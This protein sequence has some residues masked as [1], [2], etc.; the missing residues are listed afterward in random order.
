MFFHKQNKKPKIIFI[1]H[2]SA[3]GGAPIL[4]LNLL[5]WIKEN[6]DLEFDI[7]IRKKGVLVDEFK[8]LGKTIFFPKKIN[9]IKRL[10]LKLYLKRQNIKLIFSNTGTNGK[11][12]KFLSFLNCPQICYVQER[13]KLIEMFSATKFKVALKYT[14]K[15]LAA[16]EAVRNDLI[17][18]YKIAK[19]K[20]TTI[21]SFIKKP[22]S[23][24]SNKEEIRK[25]LNISKDSL[26]IGGVGGVYWIKGVD[27]FI[28]MAKIIK[29]KFKKDV[30]FIWV[31][32]LSNNPNKEQYLNSVK[33]AGLKDRF[34]F[35][36]EVKNP[37]DYMNIFDV[38]V[39]CSR[40]EAL[41]LVNLEAAFLKKPI[42]CFKDAGG[43]EE[44]VKDNAGFIVSYLDVEEMTKKIIELLKDKKLRDKLGF[45]AYRN[46]TQGF[47]IDTQAPKIIKEIKDYLSSCTNSKR[48]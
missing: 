13:E 25:K 31:G 34:H 18:Y 11:I 14:D 39:M 48:V 43:P 22:N 46:L 20:I 4:L 9:W 45:E 1:S 41:G 32:D 15:Y 27:L 29:E 3:R 10:K 8:K 16:S 6:S 17:K 2:D 36:E 40:S 44:F 30:H 24:P 21:H 12:Q 37:L 26:I 23:I 47:S 28:E 38:F 33:K 42:V 5:K 19:N 35:T 7:I